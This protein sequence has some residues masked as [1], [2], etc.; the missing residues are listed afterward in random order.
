MDENGG[1]VMTNRSP[2]HGPKGPRT[3][4][5]SDNGC[6]AQNW[7]K[8][9]LPDGYLALNWQRAE[10]KAR[11]TCRDRRFPTPQPPLRNTCGNGRAVTT[12]HLFWPNQ[13]RN[14][15]FS[16]RFLATEFNCARRER[17]NAVAPGGGGVRCEDAA[18]GFDRKASQKILPKGFPFSVL[19]LQ[20]S[21]GPWILLAGYR[22]VAGKSHFA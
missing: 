9:A 3:V 5:V 7:A 19:Q 22:D 1:T 18:K 6:G 4:V 14:P 8:G 21:A 10:I 11:V 15:P 17:N 16:L 12:S 13:R 2:D 20:K